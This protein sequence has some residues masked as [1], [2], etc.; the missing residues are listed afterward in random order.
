MPYPIAE[1]ILL[2]AS[3]RTDT[4]SRAPHGDYLARATLPILAR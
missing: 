2:S 4:G 3:K 1:K